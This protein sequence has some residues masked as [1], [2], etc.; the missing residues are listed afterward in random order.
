M[1][2]YLFTSVSKMDKFDCA[3]KLN[4]KCLADRIYLNNM[5]KRLVSTNYEWGAAMDKLLMIADDLTG[6]LDT[7]VAFAAAGIPTCVGQGDYFLHNPEAGS[8]DVQVCVV[9]TRH[10]PKEYAYQRVY[11][12]VR[13]AENCGFTRI[14]KKTDSALRGNIGAELAAVRSASCEKK[15][16]FVPAYPKMGRIT[17]D[18]VHYIDQSIPVA[19]SVFGSD[20]FNPVSHSEVLDVI[21][22]TTTVDAYR[23]APSENE[24]PKGIAVFDAATDVDLQKIAQHLIKNQNARIFAGCAGFA[25]ALRDALDFRRQDLIKAVPTG[26]LMV[27]CGSINPISL[28]QCAKAVDQGAPNFHLIHNGILAEVDSLAVNMATAAK[29]HPITIFD[30]GSVDTGADP[31]GKEIAEACSNVIKKVLDLRPEAV[32]VVIGG[33][34]LIAFMKTQEIDILSP[35]G[36][37]FPGVVLSKY[38]Y[39]GNWHF[40]ISKSGGFGNVDLLKNIYQKINGQTNLSGGCI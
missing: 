32:P 28:A 36:E 7:G 18:G 2:E 39:Q 29:Y 13:K 27:F 26:N 22:E 25:Y 1:T 14:Y 19:E 40:L 12:V 31:E 37:L 9:E 3:V 5:T 21:R 6:A 30:T 23:A 11:E 10:L 17:K 20:P 34:T 15:L 8:C 4:K 33:D 16:F 38:L 24:Y 35:L